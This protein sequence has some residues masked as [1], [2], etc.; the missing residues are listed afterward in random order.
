MG[1]LDRRPRSADVIAD[2]EV[3]AFILTAESFDRL[4]RDEPQLGQSLL[5]TIARLTAQ[6]LRVTSEELSLASS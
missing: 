1:L 4:L 3:E 5:A 6:R 2:E